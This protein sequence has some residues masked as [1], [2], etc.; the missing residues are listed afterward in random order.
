MLNRLS[1]PGTPALWVLK[2]E[3]PSG[4]GGHQS[5]WDPCYLS[6][7]PVFRVQSHI[8]TGHAHTEMPPQAGAPH[9]HGQS[10]SPQAAG[11]AVNVIIA[12]HDEDT[13]T[14]ML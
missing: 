3:S 7:N 2:G 10:T 1:Q 4:C 5:L 9:G 6:M 8:H 12:T 14:H 13:A 11:V